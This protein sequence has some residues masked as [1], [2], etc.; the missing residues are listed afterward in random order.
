MKTVVRFI[1]ASLFPLIYILFAS[2]LLSFQNTPLPNNKN[3]KDVIHWK[4]GRKLLQSDFKAKNKRLY[5]DAAAITASA[6]GFSITDSNGYI[7]GSIFVQFYRNDSWW[8]PKYKDNENRYEILAH[9]QLH[10]DICELFGRKLFKE[11]LDL[12]N[13]GRLNEE[14]INKLNSKLER[15]YSQYQD[16]YDKETNHSI[17]KEAQAKWNKKVENELRALSS[18]SEYSNF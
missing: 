14:T 7:T 3:D 8:N 1:K 17:N 11:V 4:Q 6:F 13:K 12:K 16:K 2:T 15:E 10:F 18:Y 9:E 5:G